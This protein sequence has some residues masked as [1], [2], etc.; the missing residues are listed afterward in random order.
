[1]IHILGSMNVMSSLGGIENLAFFYPHLNVPFFYM[2]HFET[3]SGSNTVQ[4]YWTYT[5]SDVD[6]L[7]TRSHYEAETS[8]T[9]GTGDAV[10]YTRSSSKGLQPLPCTFD[11][12][13][14]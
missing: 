1:M 11:T 12:R 4:I 6:S 10:P 9:K 7:V 3:V 8:L 2:A 14:V 13:I 5:Y